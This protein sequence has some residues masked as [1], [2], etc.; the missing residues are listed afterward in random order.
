[1][2][3]N[4]ADRPPSRKFAD[5][6]LLSIVPI[7]GSG[8]IRLLSATMRIQEIHRNRI[9]GH[10][11]AGRSVIL[12][13]WHDQQLMMPTRYWGAGGVSVLI[14]RH[15]DGELIARTVQRFGFQTV[16]GST[17]RGGA[18]A[19]KQMAQAARRGRDL[20]VTPDGPRGPRHRV[21]PGVIELA[22]ISGLPIFPVAFSAS[23]KKSS[24]AGTDS[25]FPIPLA[26]ACSP[27][28]SL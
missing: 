24:R 21:Q 11:G 23:K 25:R 10:W 16:R 5:R 22:K 19:L 6:M 7:L 14:S 2:T 17:S 15:R 3:F 20:A 13:F 4:I 9:E 18:S 8:L 27:G 26:E 12:A 1:M 28:G